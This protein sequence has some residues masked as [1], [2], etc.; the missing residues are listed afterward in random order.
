MHHKQSSELTITLTSCSLSSHT[1]TTSMTAFLFVSSSGSPPFTT[2]R[3]AFSLS[4]CFF[5]S[6][7]LLDI[8]KPPKVRKCY[9]RRTK[10]LA[11]LLLILISLRAH[12]QRDAGGEQRTREEKLHLDS[13]VGVEL[14][15]FRIRMEPICIELSQ[16]YDAGRSQLLRLSEAV[17]HH[18]RI[19]FMSTHGEASTS[20]QALQK[21][22]RR[23]KRDALGVSLQR[24]RN[25]ARRATRVCSA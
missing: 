17:S 18:H 25:S 22:A 24:T 10:D 23:C 21:M 16:E 1:C 9:D 19:S 3:K 4:F 11:Y 7:L 13:N 8:G 14:Y 12:G 6:R 2:D 20:C 15:S 5:C